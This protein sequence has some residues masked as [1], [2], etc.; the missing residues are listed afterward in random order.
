LTIRRPSEFPIHVAAIPA[1]V[2]AS[3]GITSPV[4]MAL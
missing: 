2:F 1:S 4:G 3:A